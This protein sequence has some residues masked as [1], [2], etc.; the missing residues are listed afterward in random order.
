MILYHWTDEAN[1]V[2]IAMSGLEPFAC[3]DA[4]VQA[5]T[6][7]HSVVW[8]TASQTRAATP[9]D[10]A[11]LRAQPDA[12]DADAIEG[13]SAHIF[14]KPDDVRLTVKFNTSNSRKLKK[15]WPW[16]QRFEACNPVT[17]ETVAPSS[18][19]AA[20]ASPT[21]REDHFVHLGRIPPSQI[22][23]PPITVRV[24][25]LGLKQNAPQREQLLRLPPDALVNLVPE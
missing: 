9:A 18:L 11:W 21:A 4:V 8:L 22:E 16:V 13:F 15:W 17:G 1:L 19:F 14:G 7:G 24:A 23:M 12:F 20:S 5:R 25:L 10:V 3:D 6:A 2:S